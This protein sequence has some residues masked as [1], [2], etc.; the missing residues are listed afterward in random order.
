MGPLTRSGKQVFL[1]FLL[2]TLTISATYAQTPPFIGQCAATS[3]PAPVRTEGLTERLGDIQIQCSGSNPGSV[4]AGNLT[5]ALPVSITNRIGSNNL[6]SDL[7]LSVDFGSGFVTLPTAAQINGN[8]IAF[9]GLSITAPASGGF[10][11]RISNLRAA[12]AQFG[13]TSN[14]PV[15]ASIQSSF[16]I[17][18]TQEIFHIMP[19]I[20]RGRLAVS[21]RGRTST[22]TTTNWSRYYSITTCSDLV[23]ENRNENRNKDQYCPAKSGHFS[24]SR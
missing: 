9:N 8:T 1:F 5:V 13:A 12:V 14:T 19:F 6:A 22:T 15:R 24:F 18:S 20:R 21:T 4:L 23:M 11:L 7:L 16:A 3:V 10:T 17:G 2:L